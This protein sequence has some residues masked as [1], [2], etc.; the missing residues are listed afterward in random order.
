MGRPLDANDSFHDELQR[1]LLRDWDPIGISSYASASDE[2]VGYGDEIFDL[3]VRGR[4]E[5][6]IFQF[7]EKSTLENMGLILVD[8]SAKNRRVAKQIVELAKNYDVY[9]G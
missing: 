6:D 5:E 2:Y 9:N 3:L 7:L 4:R 1:L 8:L